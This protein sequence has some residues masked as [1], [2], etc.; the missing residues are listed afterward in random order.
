MKIIS[1]HILFLLLLVTNSLAQDAWIQVDSLNGPPRANAVSF[2]IGDEGYITTGYD[3]SSKKRSMVS[4][5]YQQDDWDNELSLGGTTGDGLNRSSAISFTA[6]GYGFVGLGEGTGFM[7]TD[8]WMYDKYTDSWTQMANFPGGARAQAISFCIDNIGYVGLGKLS[9]LATFANDLWAYDFLTNNWSQKSDFPGTARIDAIGETLGA[10]GYVGLGHD[11]NGYP[12]DFYEYD[13]QTDNW[14]QKADF[15]GSPR[16]NAATLG[17]FPQLLVITGGDAFNYFND[18]WEYNYFGDVWIQR[19]DFPGGSRSGAC[20]FV[21]DGRAFA[22]TGYSD[23]QYFDDWYEYG[24]QLGTSELIQLNISIFPNPATTNFQI[25]LSKTEKKINI[26]IY[27]CIGQDVSAQFSQEIQDNVY[28]LNCND[29]VSGQ[30]FIIVSEE[31]KLLTTY[32]LI[33]SR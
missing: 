10:K 33:V 20:A 3:G 13:P 30:Y 19:A 24:F 15:P 5:D 26:S 7:F 21:V 9:D 8:L 6:W 1:I 31:D 32:P 18:C 16:S 17:I 2:I 12:N 14:D 23:G 28:Q 25:D 22:G 29:I 4:Y 27:N 11:S